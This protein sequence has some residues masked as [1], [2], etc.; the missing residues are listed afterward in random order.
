MLTL[1]FKICSAEG[2]VADVDV[3]VDEW[4][5]GVPITSQCD[6]VKVSEG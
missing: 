2:V 4:E 3:D 1:G 5:P 6:S